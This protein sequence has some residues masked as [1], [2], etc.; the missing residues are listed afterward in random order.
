MAIEI[1]LATYDKQ[2]EILRK[3]KDS[4]VSYFYTLASFDSEAS[5]SDIES[6][7]GL[8]HIN[9]IKQSEVAKRAFNGSSLCINAVGGE[10]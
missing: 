10:I 8:D 7:K 9:N 2:N 6:L 5:Q 3:A 4:G 1:N